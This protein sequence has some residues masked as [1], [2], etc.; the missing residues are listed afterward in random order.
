[1]AYL[2][3]VV[4]RTGY[5]CDALRDLARVPD[6]QRV[7]GLEVNLPGRLKVGALVLTSCLGNIRR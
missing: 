6:Q 3:R 7:G 5:G 1:M 2:R 4:V